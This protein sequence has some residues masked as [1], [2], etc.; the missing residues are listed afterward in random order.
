MDIFLSLIVIIIM[1]NI[2][3]INFRAENNGKE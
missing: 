3:M 1:K 2:S